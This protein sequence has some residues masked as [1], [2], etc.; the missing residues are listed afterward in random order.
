MRQAFAHE[1]VV[2]LDGEGDPRALGAVI[3]VGLCGSWD[4][5]P[6][7]PLAP[8]HTGVQR[9][10]PDLRLRVLFAAEPADEATVRQRIDA[11][12]AASTL[13]GPEGRTSRW[14]VERTGPSVVRLDEA[15]HVERLVRS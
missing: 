7:C 11:A 3:T 2:R 5:E 10:G 13:V 6:P 15:R 8:H 14:Q 9:A 12:L 4:H 1:A